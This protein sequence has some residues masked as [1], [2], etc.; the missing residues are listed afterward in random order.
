MRIV[1]EIDESKHA[2]P[3]ATLSAALPPD[4]AAPAG[5]KERSATA[6]LRPARA[7]ANDGGPAPSRDA[8][9]ADCTEQASPAPGNEPAQ[10]ANALSAGSAPAFR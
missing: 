4:Q 10:S 3:T 7:D 2:S 1:I 5:E 8:M 6:A 9:R